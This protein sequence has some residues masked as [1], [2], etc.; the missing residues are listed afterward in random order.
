MLIYCMRC[1]KKLGEKEPLEDKSITH[2]VCEPCKEIILAK[3]KEI[4]AKDQK[5]KSGP[6]LLNSEEKMVYNLLFPDTLTS[7]DVLVEQTRRSVSEILCILLN[8]E[9]KELVTQ[10]PGKFYQRKL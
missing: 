3:A 2:G 4:I 9:I 6:P 5:E 7:V 8:L 1:N 10:R